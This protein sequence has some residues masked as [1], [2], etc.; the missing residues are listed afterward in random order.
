MTKNEMISAV[1]A[2]AGLTKKQ[3]NDSIVALVDTVAEQL[4]AG[5]VFRLIGFGTFKT[6]RREAHQGRNPRTGETVQVKESATVSFKPGRE[7]KAIVKTGV[8]TSASTA[9]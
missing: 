4:A 2:K 6:K 3:A 7:L 5:E 8:V 9:E 1:A